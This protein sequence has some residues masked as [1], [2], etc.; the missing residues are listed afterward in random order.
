MAGDDPEG[1]DDCAIEGTA[2]LK[3]SVGRIVSVRRRGERSSI[4]DSCLHR[5][6]KLLA[7]GMGV[8]GLAL[9]AN[10]EREAGREW[11]LLAKGLNT[12]AFLV[13]EIIMSRPCGERPGNDSIHCRRE[14]DDAKGTLRSGSC[15]G[16]C[17]SGVDEKAK[18]PRRV[19]VD[20]D[21]MGCAELHSPETNGELGTFDKPALD[22]RRPW[23]VQGV[24]ICGENASVE[25][26]YE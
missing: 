21:I 15:E 4:E 20:D 13:G 1:S 3:T 11:P 25:R 26:E 18:L 7:A 9:R 10:G 2:E 8:V 19:A 6:D 16:R 14:G 23:C 5:G 12:R 24:R 17:D 22:M